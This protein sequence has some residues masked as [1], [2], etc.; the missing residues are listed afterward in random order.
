MGPTMNGSHSIASFRGGT[1]PVPSPSRHS[2]YRA[3]HGGVQA[4][5]KTGGRHPKTGL[6]GLA[7]LHL[8]GV[9]AGGHGFGLGNNHGGDASVIADRSPQTGGDHPG[10]KAS[11]PGT[12]SQ[13]AFGHSPPTR[14]A[15]GASRAGARHAAVMRRLGSDQ[16]RGMATGGPML[17]QGTAFGAGA[18]SSGGASAQASG[19][20]GSPPDKPSPSASKKAGRRRRFGSARPA[21]STPQKDRHLAPI[22]RIASAHFKRAV[23]SGGGDGPPSPTRR[24][25]MAR[26]L[27]PSGSSASSHPSRPPSRQKN[28]FPTHLSEFDT[29][30]PKVG[31]ARLC[32]SVAVCGCLWLWLCVGLCVS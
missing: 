5:E 19:V 16:R 17:A 20:S 31:G 23:P 18:G 29:N 21:R 30:E 10:L 12:R 14:A 9:G 32:V 1:A 27:E 11:A 25:R 28:A 4:S 6:S 26:L 15:G 2:R 7:G 22:P 24:E 3:R 13:P 8:G